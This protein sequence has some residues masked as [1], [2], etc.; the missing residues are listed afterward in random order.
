MREN[1][2]KLVKG[3]ATVGV[4]G[5][6][7]AALIAAAHSG[8]SGVSPFFPFLV[9]VGGSVF[10]NILDRAAHGQSISDEELRQVLD[11]PEQIE[12]VRLLMEQ[13]GD[14]VYRVLEDLGIDIQAGMDETNLRLAEI[15]ETQADTLE[16]VISVRAESAD[17]SALM[18]AKLNAILL[19]LSHDVAIEP[20]HEEILKAY[21][22]AIANKPSY[23]R[24]NAGGMSA[25]SGNLAGKPLEP[26]IEDTFVEPSLARSA[27]LFEA[28]AEIVGL[29][30]QCHDEDE[31]SSARDEARRR[32][33]G[34]QGKTWES[35]RQGDSACS[36]REALAGKEAVVILGDPGSG[37][38]TLL[39]WQ[40][41]EHAATI[42]QGLDGP[43]PVFIPIGDYA[44]AC[45]SKLEK[46]L[47][48]PLQHYLPDR[49]ETEHHGMGKV[50]ERA[51]LPDGCGVMLLLDGLDEVPHDLRLKAAHGIQDFIAVHTGDDKRSRVVVSSR[52]FGFQEA[53]IGE[54]A[55][56]LAIMPFDDEQ[57]RTFAK[58]WCAWVEGYL[59]P[60]RHEPSV[61]LDNAERLL[62]ILFAK[63]QITALAR[64]PLMLSMIA[65]I[66]RSDK[67]LPARRVELY[68]MTLRR[69][70]T[71]WHHLRSEVS[72]REEFRVDFSEAC[73]IWAPIARWMH[74]VGTGAVY[75]SELKARLNTRLKELE[76]D[77]D[78][79]EWL[80]V[81]GDKCCLLQER[82][83]GIF[84]FLH[85]TF[86]EYLAAMDINTDDGFVPQLREY[87][88]SPHWQ[89][90]I[91]LACGFLG[92]I[93]VPPNKKAVS[94][95]LVQVWHNGSEFEGLL[96]RDLFL[97]ANCLSDDVRPRREIQES[98]VNELLSIVAADPVLVV[99][100]SCLGLLISNSDVTLSS[101]LLSQVIE[102]VGATDDWGVMVQ[103]NQILGA[104][105][106]HGTHPRLLEL[107]QHEDCNV[108]ITAQ[109]AIWMRTREEDRL[110]AILKDLHNAVHRDEIKE[111]VE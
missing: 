37:K 2:E 62:R 21:A 25:E 40:M 108:R 52:F 104:Q 56:H 1:I 45:E 54:P 3:G 47:L 12:A 10:A 90:V 57:I 89:E 102:I 71:R 31:T 69:L 17:V 95:L 86:Q 41:V 58:R 103:L 51:L 91:R 23:T 39:R 38:S 84:G 34:L 53:P 61:A 33:L 29:L 105:S 68:D 63:P 50:L 65:V 74:E 80:T 14:A 4:Y 9:M 15:Q 48:I 100:E 32:V 49:L 20:D 83:P 30:Q 96:H 6:C 8:A 67:R 110:R 78:A 18:I 36:A 75:E 106:T 43:I 97:A 27:S 79:N 44:N 59:H 13:N 111:C 98:I 88:S 70:M 76:R 109:T 35:M 77:E 55:I 99:V 66:E 94:D 72:E 7:A 19:R 22:E 107:V 87:V 82:G 24:M 60:D 26:D 73:Q 5:A 85:Q 16:N 11:T 81:R 46:G 42:A 93:C 64:N 101:E 28:R 92:V